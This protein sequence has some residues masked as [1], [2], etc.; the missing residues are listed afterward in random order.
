MGF[1]KETREILSL[2]NLKNT[3]FCYISPNKG[4]VVEGYKKIYELSNIKIILLCEDTKK[5]EIIG[6]NLSVK[7]IAHKEISILGNINTINFT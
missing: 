5:L 1:I 4:V 2:T 7:E 6:T 3:T